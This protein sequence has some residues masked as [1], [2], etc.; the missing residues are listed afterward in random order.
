VSRRLIINGREQIDPRETRAWRRLRDQVVI[1]EPICRLQLDCCTGWS[2]TAD[3][4]VPVIERPDLALVRD[5]LRGACHPCNIRRR[6]KPAGQVSHWN[7]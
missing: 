5:N 3:H 4:I 2:Q 6:I 1:E 7:L